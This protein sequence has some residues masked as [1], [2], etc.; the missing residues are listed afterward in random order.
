MR[1]LRSKRG[2]EF[3]TLI[4]IILLIAGVGLL[5]GIILSITSKADQSTQEQLCR[6]FNALKFGY[7]KSAGS[8]A[9][10]LISPPRACNT[11]DKGDLP[12]KDFKAR[13]DLAND[14]TRAKA[15]V[16][17]LMRRCW[18]MWLEGRQQNMFDKALYQSD[19]CFVCYTFSVGKG[20]GFSS[21]DLVTSLYEPYIA[22]DSSNRCAG[23]VSAGGGSLGG[24][25][26]S[27]SFGGT[28]TPLGNGN[29]N[30]GRCMASCGGEFPDKASSASCP[31]NQVCCVS[32]NRQNECEDKGG[33]CSSTPLNGYKQFLDWK[34][35]GKRACFVS[36]N[37]F[38]SYLD[39][40]QGTRGAGYGSGMVVYEDGTSFNPGQLYAVTLVSPSRTWSWAGTVGG[41]AIAV[42]TLGTAGVITY[43][44]GFLGLPIA[45]KL[46]IVGLGAAAATAEFSGDPRNIN[47][48][49]V[50]RYDTVST[51]C[52]IQRGAAS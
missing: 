4:E 49:F 25:G 32:T 22:K 33:V 8:L 52:A 31:S 19:G 18:W 23:S 15:E 40:L 48:I 50:S 34:C 2:L 5:I 35:T 16:R 11:L 27:P 17:D 24:A 29:G 43:F 45:T 42:A 7:E 9:S 20:A 6:G 36:E 21:T 26:A 14:A 38:A 46:T 37:N 41:G 13:Q 51:K 12:S 1:F 10:K 3:E 47:Y 30:G 39:Y 44:T 28:T